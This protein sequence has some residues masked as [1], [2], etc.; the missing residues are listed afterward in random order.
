MCSFPFRSPAGS[1][2][3]P[4]CWRTWARPSPLGR[5]GLVRWGEEVPT[6]EIAE[7]LRLVPED[8]ILVRERH[9]FVD[10]KPV[11]PTISHIPMQVAGGTDIAMPGT[12][13]F[14]RVHDGTHLLINTAKNDLG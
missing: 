10:E 11:Q 12:G 13:T 1:K 2:L 8:R 14:I 5:T 6:E 3:R 4:I 7:V 9:V